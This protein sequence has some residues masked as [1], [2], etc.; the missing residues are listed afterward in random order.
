MEG[1]LHTSKFQDRSTGLD[2]YKTEIVVSNVILNDARGSGRG[3]GGE[4]AESEPTG[5]GGFDDADYGTRPDDDD[6]PF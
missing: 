1:K 4:R 6:I 5:G 2:R 3:G